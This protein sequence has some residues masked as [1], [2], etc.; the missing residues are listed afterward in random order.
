MAS[1]YVDEEN[2][3]WIRTISISKKVIGWEPGRPM[4]PVRC[5]RCM[6]VFNRVNCNGSLVTQVWNVDV[7]TISW[8]IWYGLLTEDEGG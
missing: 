2:S 8:A 3:L 5:S 4:R 1:A 6:N 7:L